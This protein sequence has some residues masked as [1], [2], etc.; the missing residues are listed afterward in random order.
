MTASS[1]AAFACDRC[2]VV[3][4]L[5]EGD[6]LTCLGCHGLVCASCVAERTACCLSCAA[7]GRQP[8]TSRR[9][10][11][12]VARRA[13]LQHRRLV[14]SAPDQLWR[15]ETN[16][17]AREILEV[18][19]ESLASTATHALKSARRRDGDAGDEVASGLELSKWAWV[20]ASAASVRGRRKRHRWVAIV[21][22][23]A[24]MALAILFLAMA[25]YAVTS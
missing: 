2:K 10:G 7:V 14:A 15:S 11:V 17:V 23:A 24:A 19:L 6:W 9:S 16:D 20:T 25:A 8:W 1:S 18:Q 13:V 12:R 4:R 3:K 5:G 21:R 22:L